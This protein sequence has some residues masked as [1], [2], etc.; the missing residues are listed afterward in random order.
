MYFNSMSPAGG[1]ERV[2][3]KHIAFMNDQHQVILVTKDEQPSF[4]SLP[5]GLRRESLNV[6]FTLNMRS[7]WQRVVKVALTSLKTVAALRKKIKAIRPDVVYV[8][9]PL[10]LLEVCLAGVSSRRVI[11]TE[12]SS[13]SAYNGVYKKIIS[14]LY[15]RVGQL[16][17]PTTLDSEKYAA[18][19]IRNVYLPNP[20][21]FY[22]Q[23][24]ADLSDRRVLCIGRL[25]DDKRHA[26]LLDIWHAS[27]LQGLGWTLKI[28]GKGE[29]EPDLRK[30][31][32]ELALS[33]SVSIERP[34]S[35]IQSELMASSI[36]LLTSRAEGFGLV[37]AEAMACGV[38]CISFDCPSGPRDIID[39]DITGR[40]VAEGDF[41][42][43]VAALQELA[44]DP[45]RRFDF[46]RQSK[47]SVKKFHAER[48]GG[49]FRRI[50]GEAFAFV[51]PSNILAP[52]L[53][54]KK[55][56]NIQ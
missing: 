21:P 34:T 56:G 51:R 23:A 39:D 35:D 46:G 24:S 36:F 2:I 12:H 43:Y 41:H 7:R 10:N 9:S 27:N 50:L 11:V 18:R 47:L 5:D 55:N 53:D 29:R 49:E 13:F 32:D 42:G 16:L 45:V 20:L 40:L 26:L 37:L 52:D 48:V 15:P 4:F 54:S 25:T 17:V 30:K 14:V 44:T 31:I 8:A 38:P 19:G 33:A 3:A 22:P 28:I 6:D 1:I